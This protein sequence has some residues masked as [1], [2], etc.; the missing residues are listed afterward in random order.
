MD[1]KIDL[2]ELRKKRK[3]EEKQKEKEEAILSKER[4]KVYKE[5]TEYEKKHKKEPKIAPSDCYVALEHINKI[6][7]NRVQAVYDFNLRIKKNEFIVFV[8]PSGCGKSTTLRMIAGLEDITSGDLFIDGVYANDL[9][10]KDRNIS[11]VFQSYALYPH[12]TVYNNMAFG[13][14]MRH[15]PRDEIDDR[16]HRA[17]KILQIEEYLDRKPRAL[18]GGQCQRVALGRAIVRN[19]KIFLMDEPLSNLDAKLR[20]QMR[21]EIVKLHEELGATTVYVT[22]DQTEAMTMASRIVVLKGGYIQQVGTP[23]EIYNKPSNIFVATFIGSPAMN[24]IK[25]K[26]SGNTITLQSGFEIEINNERLETLKS[27]YLNEI[28]SLKSEIKKVEEDKNKA[29]EKA[30]LRNKE[31]KELDTKINDNMKE[32]NS[33]KDEI[34]TNK[35]VSKIKELE[36]V[37]QNKENDLKNATNDLNNEKSFFLKW[38]FKKE[39]KGLNKDIEGLN[40]DINNLKSNLDK[41]NDEAFNKDINEKIK[42]LENENLELGEKIISKKDEL[43]RTLDMNEFNSFDEKVKN[44][45]DTITRYEVLSKN[46]DG[47]YLL[48][49]RPEDIAQSNVNNNFVEPSKTF[50]LKVDVAELLGN[51][52]YVHTKVLD[53]TLLAK[54][55]AITDIKHNDE[56]ELMLDISKIH[57]FNKDNERLIW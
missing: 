37:K 32:I 52:Y 15:V 33:L 6:Y 12:M 38:S 21:S 50:K 5:V 34:D 29:I 47:D 54:V 30:L 10:P 49:I 35:F 41:S 56:I 46:P 42:T 11:M 36:V 26:L 20:V 16:V 39:I 4:D 43:L 18:S 48:G 45:N 55:N 17:A 27:Y 9:E 13:L 14:K 22:H 53:E 19:S 7:S 28:E 57:L 40:Y 51:E 44:L 24:I 8:G 1:E 31:F 23:K 25:A 2:K 3:E